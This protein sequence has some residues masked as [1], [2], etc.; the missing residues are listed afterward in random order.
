MS[1][2]RF[3]GYVVATAATLFVVVG[4]GLLVWGFGH[5]IGAW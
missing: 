4:L 5:T 1:Y 3:L 2:T